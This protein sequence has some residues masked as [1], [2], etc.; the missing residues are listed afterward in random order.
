MHLEIL[1]ED[2]SGKLLLEAILPTILGAHTFRVISYKGIGRLP[3]GLKPKA[4]ASARILL[5]RL[6]SLLAGYGR[7]YPNVPDPT[8]AVVVVCDLDDKCLVKF[9]KSLDDIV[10]NCHPAPL[11]GFA[12]AIEEMEAWILG[13]REAIL[14]AFPNAKNAVLQSYVQDSIC[15]TWEVLADAIHSGGALE[16]NK[17]GWPAKGIAKSNWAST[18]SPE[19]EVQRNLSPSFKYFINKL[20]QI[21]GD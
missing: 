8:G 2:A 16:L 17:S 19:M 7:V 1:V 5:D 14:A 21:T 11:V 20:N 9:R 18:I 6:P 15:G 4:D 10:E 3:A 13:D 12:V